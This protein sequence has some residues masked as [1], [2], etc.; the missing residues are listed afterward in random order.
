MPIN[1]NIGIIVA[2]FFISVQETKRQY[3]HNYIEDTETV[4]YQSIIQA[5]KTI[6]VIIMFCTYFVV[7]LLLH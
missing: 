3:L 2:L 4:V 1:N 6:T 5:V 7:F